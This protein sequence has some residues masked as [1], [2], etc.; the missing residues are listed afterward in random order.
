MLLPHAPPP[1]SPLLHSALLRRT[2][3]GNNIG[4]AGKEAVRSAAGALDEKRLKHGGQ[5][6]KINLYVD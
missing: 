2:T 5:G 1:A 6:K 4:A 3:A